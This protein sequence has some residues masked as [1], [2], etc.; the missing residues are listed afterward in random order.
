MS[1]LGTDWQGTIYV[2]GW[3]AG[4]GEPIR[5]TEPAT[6]EQLGTIGGA[7]PQDLARAAGRSARP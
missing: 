4:G 7:S 3:T 2:N 6:G 1:F 5:V